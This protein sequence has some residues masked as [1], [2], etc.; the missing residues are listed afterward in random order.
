MSARDSEAPSEGVATLEELGYGPFF[1]SSLEELVAER[2]EAPLEPARV[3]RADRGVLRL[4]AGDGEIDAPTPRRSKSRSVL[5]PV[6][7]D[8]LAIARDAGGQAAVVSVLPRRSSFVR[9]AAGRST[10][11]QV[12]AAN[13]DVLLI[14]TSLDGDFNP[15]RLERYLALAAQSGAE[16][17]VVVNKID[18]C[19]TPDAYQAEAVAHA[20][21]APVVL[22][23]AKSGDGLVALT[24][25]LRPAQT[26]ALL[27]SSGVGKSTL[28][29]R[30][31]GEE[32]MRT[33]VVRARDQRGQHTTSHRELIRL[34]GGA[35]LI[36]TPGMRELGLWGE[37]TKVEEAFDDVERLIADCRF[38][39]CSHRAEPGC[40]VQ[41]AVA[42]GELEPSRL[43]SFLKLVGELDAQAARRRE[44]ERATYKRQGKLTRTLKRG[45]R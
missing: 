7:G 38:A 18:L 23:C 20:G 21:G 5:G 2:A 35:L 6:V 25:H 42:A 39:D 36:D 22:C 45:P 40:A 17:V 24:P 34:P 33:R 31:L 12:V 29:N 8:W 11:A 13:F 4:A 37:V 9:R 43:A 27:G 19:Q 3:L 41:A 10:R 28:V 26:V 14:V 1:A 32:R 16:A 30:L 44:Q 15:R